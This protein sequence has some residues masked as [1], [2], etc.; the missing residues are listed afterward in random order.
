MQVEIKRGPYLTPN[1]PLPLMVQTLSGH[2]WTTVQDPPAG[3]TR[4]SCSPPRASHCPKVV[5]YLGLK[6]REQLGHVATIAVCQFI[7]N[8]IQQVLPMLMRCHRNLT[9]VGFC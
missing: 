3:V 2:K 9:L 1:K 7:D 8:R 6:P 4:H 5:S